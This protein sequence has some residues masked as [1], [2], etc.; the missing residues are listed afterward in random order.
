MTS[1]FL[2]DIQPMLNSLFLLGFCPFTFINDQLHCN[3]LTFVYT[4]FYLT[5]LSSLSVYTSRLT[6]IAI[7]KSITYPG[8]INR[9][10]DEV[11]ELMIL[12]IN[13]IFFMRSIHDRYR[14]AAFLNRFADAEL[15][16]NNNY[17]DPTQL[18]TSKR[19][20]AAV[21]TAIVA[22]AVVTLTIELIW[23]SPDVSM[24]VVATD[25]V[26]QFQMA[27]TM[28]STFYVRF[29]ANV[30]GR[31]LTNLN[32]MLEKQ[33]ACDFRSNVQTKDL[34]ALMTTVEVYYELKRNL[35]GIFKIYLLID[36]TFDFISVTA[37]A[38]S[39]CV[40]AMFEWAYSYYEWFNLF[41]LVMPHF[42]TLMLVVKVLDALSDQVLYDF[43]FNIIFQALVE[44]VLVFFVNRSVKSRKNI[45]IFQSLFYFRL[46]KCSIF[47]KYLTS[48]FM[49]TIILNTV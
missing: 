44:V 43:F 48:V 17:A 1:L 24:E 8:E 36:I 7:S 13:L 18:Y 14:H 37:A 46:R 10:S 2:K 11:T 16:F 28:G 3:R 31:R 12:T 29:L 42:L 40:D 6:I 39:L 32:E 19:K 49:S 30:I 20:I 4:I 45:V 35:D 5:I 22:Y 38:F 25:L 41:G 26:Y 9:L 21:I 27:T 34:F 15:M 47:L 23:A 33:L